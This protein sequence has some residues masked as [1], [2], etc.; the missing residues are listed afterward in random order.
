MRLRVRPLA[1]TVQHRVKSLACSLQ[2]ATLKWCCYFRQ[3]CSWLILNLIQ[4][5]KEFFHLS[6]FAAFQ[7]N[8]RFCFVKD[9]SE[10][11]PRNFHLFFTS[12]HYWGWTASSLQT[13]GADG[14]RYL[15]WKFLPGLWLALL[16]SS[17]ASF[18]WFWELSW[19]WRVLQNRKP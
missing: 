11:F 15:T 6:A 13:R 14:K 5:G 16:C 8:R 3:P 9:V 19:K 18:H 12:V 10:G 1:G 4:A 2:A 17:F 7:F